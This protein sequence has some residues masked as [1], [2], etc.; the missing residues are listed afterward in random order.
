MEL[1]MATEKSRALAPKRYS[2]SDLITDD[3]LINF[4]RTEEEL[5]IF[6]LYCGFSVNK[7]RR[8][9]QTALAK[10]L[11]MGRGSLPFER[12]RSLIKAGRLRRCLEQTGIGA[13]TRLEGFLRNVV[14]ANI[15]LRQGSVDD[16][17]AIHGIG[18]TKARLFVLCTR[19]DARCA[20]LDTHILKFLREQGYAK[21]P[22]QSPESLREY[23]RLEGY[24]LKEV[25]KSGMT[26][27]QYNLKRWR[28]RAVS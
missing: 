10:L 18:P 11:D 3:N 17:D 2:D 1:P 26:P 23:E 28:E 8:H 21:V 16:Y 14:S 25:D 24:W 27:A 15:D 20:V 4:A 12:I 5:Q 6:L 7:T 22:E 13:Y 9:A 19:E